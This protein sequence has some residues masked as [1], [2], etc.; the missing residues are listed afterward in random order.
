MSKGR[1]ED[2]YKIITRIVAIIL[3]IAMVLS[4]AGTLIYYLSAK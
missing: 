4:V 3:A 1:K 2:K